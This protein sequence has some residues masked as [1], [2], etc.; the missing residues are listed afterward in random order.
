MVDI[1]L[2]GVPNPFLNVREEKMRRKLSK[3][4]KTNPNQEVIRGHSFFPS[5]YSHIGHFLKARELYIAEHNPENVWNVPRSN[6]RNLFLGNL[7]ENSRNIWTIFRLLPT[8]KKGVYNPIN[9]FKQTQ[10]R[11]RRVNILL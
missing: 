10:K 7:P 11:E 3:T 8:A 5:V 9:V 4:K 2:R 6:A 1:F